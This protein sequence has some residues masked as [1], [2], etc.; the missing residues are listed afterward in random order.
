[1]PAQAYKWPSRHVLEKKV[2]EFKIIRFFVF[3]GGCFVYLFVFV[4]DGFFF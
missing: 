4:D 1:M 2:E 3:L